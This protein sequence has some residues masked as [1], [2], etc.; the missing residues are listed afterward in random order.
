[1]N[2]CCTI[3]GEVKSKEDWVS[4]IISEEYHKRADIEVTPEQYFQDCVNTGGLVE[5]E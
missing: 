3:S 5:V 4:E 2:Y 1:M